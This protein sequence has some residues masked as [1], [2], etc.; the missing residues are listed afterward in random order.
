M[1][2]KHFYE[3]QKYTDDY[4]FHYCRKNIFEFS[5]KNSYSILEIGCAEGGS[6]SSFKKNL[7]DKQ[8]LVLLG[9]E[10]VEGRINLGK[11]HDPELDLIVGD[12]TDINIVDKI[13]HKFDLIIIRDVIEH[14]QDKEKAIKNMFSLLKPYGHIFMTFPLKYS[15]YA[16]HQQNC[17]IP[18]RYFLYISLFSKRFISLICK[19]SGQ[20]EFFNELLYLKRNTLSY[21]KL[22]KLVKNKGEFVKK[23]FFIFRPIFKQR[24]GLPILRMPNIPLFR[25]LALGCEV[26]IKKK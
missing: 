19:I 17:K 14:I 12:I 1:A 5:K 24:F 2:E 3:Q 18:L 20:N 4:L 15:P 25:E 10:I 16:G 22:T 8:E 23:D 11:K 7:K 6:L 26:L 9:I 21:Y 13:N